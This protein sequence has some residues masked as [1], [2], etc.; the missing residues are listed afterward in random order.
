VIADGSYPILFPDLP[1]AVPPRQR[2]RSRS[3]APADP[4]A[5]VRWPAPR[6]DH[7]TL[8]LALHLPDLP[9]EALE[10]GVG[11][12]RAVCETRGRRG[13][14]VAVDAAA[15]AAGLRPGMSPAS[16]CT[17]CLALTLPERQPRLEER[18]LDALA[19]G[20]L[21]FTP[22]LALA[23][24]GLLLDVGGSLR[25]FGGLGPLVET[26][27][28]TALGRGHRAAM[29]AAPTAAAA[30]LLA[31]AGGE[32]FITDRARLTAPL[33]ALPIGLLEMEEKDLATLAGCGI[34]TIGELLRLPRDGL[35]RRFP[36]TLLTALDRL[37]GR[38]PDPRPLFAPGRFFED[39]IELPAG[40]HETV[41][42]AAGELLV[43]LEDEL[44]RACAGVDRLLC[45]LGHNDGSR[46]RVEL[47][48][49]TPRQRRTDLLDLL[50]V[51]LESVALPAPAV[52]L[53]LRS[54]RY[55]P[56]P[57]RPSTLLPAE[58]GSAAP[59][60]RESLLERLRLRLGE[61]AVHG[62]AVADEHRPEKAWRRCRPGEQGLPC[63]PLPP[64]PCW[65]LEQP[66]PLSRRL[67]RRQGLALEG[68]VER[69][70]GGWWDGHPVARDYRI[71]RNRHGH[72]L[73]VFRDLERQ[74][75]Y[76]HGYF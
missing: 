36:P 45:R 62:I 10:D 39:D 69:I 59:E 70:V 33:A 29:A 53:H 28:A 18:R 13:Q 40:D 16:A 26:A 74:G 63:P 32:H 52:T 56:L 24:A 41:L 66:A 31:R 5:A 20:L 48:L 17:L 35:G 27:R 22:R 51:R 7:A 38:S 46:T 47:A 14:V 61:R 2:S 73:W 15:A 25:L 37:L 12:P 43:R 60:A 67:R 19:H 8:W 11:G 55:R 71:A 75:W 65:L 42:A 3:P 6:P 58:R 21:A 44:R 49:A 76:L 23:P 54:G 50:R 68:D 57:D 72:R 9:L 34:R 1:A 4:G 30:L 64:R